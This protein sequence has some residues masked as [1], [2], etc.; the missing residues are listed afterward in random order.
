LPGAFTQGVGGGFAFG[1]FQQSAAVDTCTNRAF[2][3]SVGSVTVLDARS[4]VQVASVPVSG[5]AN[6]IVVDSQTGDVYVADDHG[7]DVLDGRSGRVLRTV[8][9]GAPAS[10]VGLDARRGRLFVAHPGTGE[11][12]RA[13]TGSGTVSVLDS[14]TGALLRTA[15]VGVAPSALAVD[16]QT[17]QA[18]VVNSGGL[19][20]DRD[21]WSWVPS[22][23]QRWVPFRKQ[24]APSTHW[25]AGSV[26]I[27][28]GVQ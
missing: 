4:G 12:S 17:G 7:I 18:I 5:Y 3:G 21:G 23:L 10:A 24:Q 27:V 9:T 1:Y 22:S 28:D 25:V 6:H 8:S 20:Q 26:S 15:P 19:V 13:S 14:R 2:I 16:E 11:G